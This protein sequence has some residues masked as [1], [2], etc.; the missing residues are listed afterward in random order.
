MDG[1]SSCL[2]G[3]SSDVTGGGERTGLNTIMVDSWEG[4]KVN[5]EEET[6]PDDRY[7]LI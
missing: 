1:N 7:W 3:G 4:S 6:A 5:G 2:W